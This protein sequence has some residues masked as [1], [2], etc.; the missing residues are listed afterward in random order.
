MFRLLLVPGGSHLR[1]IDGGSD[2]FRS[3]FSKFLP[4]LGRVSEMF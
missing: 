2:A 1:E 4:N 3:H